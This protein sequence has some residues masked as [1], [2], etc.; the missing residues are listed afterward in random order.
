[1]MKNFD[2]LYNEIENTALTYQPR[3]LFADLK[4]TEKDHHLLILYGAG[5]NCE[6]ALI[7]CEEYGISLLGICDREMT[8]VYTYKT[9]SYKIISLSELMKDYKDAFIL[10]TSWQKEQENYDF[11]RAIGFKNTQIYFF[12]YPGRLS[13]KLFREKYL[14][15]YRNVYNFFTD[16]D[17]RQCILDKTQLLLTGKSYR[18][19]LLYHE[20]YFDCPDI[21]LREN[22]NFADVGAYTG[23]TALEFINCMKKRD[24]VYKHIYSFEADPFNFERAAKNLLGYNNID[25]IHCGISSKR[26]DLKF[27][28]SYETDG[29]KS[30]IT[31][32]DVD[33]II[34]PMTSLDLFFA[35]KQINEWPTIIKINIGEGEKEALIGALHIIQ[36][37]KPQL[38]ISVGYK[39]EDIFE[40]PQTILQIRSDYKLS[41]RQTG[42]GF[43]NMILYAV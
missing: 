4:D 31:S 5:K 1:M 38:I 42:P 33:T 6:S 23:D 24:K 13:P 27:I 18:T 17:S 8:G 21:R 35:D 34:V 12:R 19:G 10:I 2:E 7:L 22:E 30:H 36:R 43:S 26:I 41:L 29:L 32:D 14:A 11:L 25:L 3:N 28:C 37:K 40:L 16:T 39:S 20:G 15:R 9:Q